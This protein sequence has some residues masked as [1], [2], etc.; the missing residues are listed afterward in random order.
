MPDDRMDF[1]PVDC[2]VLATTEAAIKIGVDH[3]EYWIPRSLCDDPDGISIDDEEVSIRR[4][5]V[6]E[7]GLN[8]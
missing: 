8:D 4:W 7:L 6:D 2:V 1:V 5:K 3:G